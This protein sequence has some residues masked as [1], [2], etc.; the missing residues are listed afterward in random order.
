MVVSTA[1]ALTLHSPPLSP[2]C[3][4]IPVALPSESPRT[5]TTS[6]RHC[7]QPGPAWPHLPRFW[8]WPPGTFPAFPNLLEKHATPNLFPTW[9]PT[10][11]LKMEARSVIQ[12]TALRRPCGGVQALCDLMTP[13]SSPLLSYSA[14]PT[15]PPARRDPPLGA[16]ALAA[17]LPQAPSRPTPH[18]SQAPAQVSP[19]QAGPPCC[20]DPLYPAA[21]ISLLQTLAAACCIPLGIYIC[22]LALSDRGQ[23]SRSVTSAWLWTPSSRPGPASEWPLRA[24]DHDSSPHSLTS[25]REPDLWLA[26]HLIAM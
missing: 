21:L 13:T 2:N 4:P 26:L 22:L 7:C 14:E 24:R 3:P 12:L 25:E 6:H 16:F 15:L 1:P 11:P 9:R 17:P 5:R 20:L 8:C 23:E 18:F 10:D 19:L